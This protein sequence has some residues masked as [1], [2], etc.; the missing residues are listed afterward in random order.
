MASSLIDPVKKTFNGVLHND[1]IVLSCLA[2]IVGAAAGYAA[3]GF[4]MLAD[5]VA[6]LLYG[7]SETDLHLV[8]EHV[9]WWLILLGPAAGGLVIGLLCVYALPGPVPQVI[10]TLRQGS[11]DTRSLHGATGQVVRTA[12]TPS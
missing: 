2:V 10:G 11:V 12:S 9:D 4:R 5:L 6:T 7:V 8:H 1:Q 3:I